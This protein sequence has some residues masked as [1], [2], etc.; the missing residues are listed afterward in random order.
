MTDRSCGWTKGPAIGIGKYGGG[1]IMLV[2]V[3]KERSLN[4]G[5]I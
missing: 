4:Y 1:M 2:I 5:S 3:L